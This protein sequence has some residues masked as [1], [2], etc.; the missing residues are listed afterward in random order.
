MATETLKNPY[1]LQT[2]TFKLSYEGKETK[3]NAKRKPK[4]TYSVALIMAYLAAENEN[5][6]LED[7]L[8]SA[9]G[10]LKISSVCKDQVKNWEFYILKIRPIVRF[11]SDSKHV[12]ILSAPTHFTIFIW[13]LSILRFSAIDKVNFAYHLTGGYCVYMIKKIIYASHVDMKLL[14]SC[15]ARNLTGLVSS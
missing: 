13:G 6:Q 12:F 9:F 11:C 5:R 8:Q 4:I 15:S 2:V 1:R 14:F 7:L 10:S 3:I